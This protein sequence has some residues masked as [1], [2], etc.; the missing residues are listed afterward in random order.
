MHQEC[1]LILNYF[2]L[3]VMQYINTHTHTHTHMC[4]HTHTHTYR[5]TYVDMQIHTHTHTYIFIPLLY[6]F[7]PFHQTF[8]PQEEQ[9]VFQVVGQSKLHIMYI[10]GGE[11][12]TPEVESL[13]ALPAEEMEEGKLTVF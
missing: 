5:H 3:P 9:H 2:E 1:L 8:T 7:I 11:P 4:I 13:A 6:Y 10:S 12:L